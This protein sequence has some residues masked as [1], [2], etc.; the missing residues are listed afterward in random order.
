MKKLGSD[1]ASWKHSLS[2]R[3]NNEARLRHEACD[4]CCNRA[5][6]STRPKPLL[7][8]LVF[9]DGRDGSEKNCK[10]KLF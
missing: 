6:K 8:T 5:L 1:L 2:C 4:C 3:A 10:E 7:L 9:S